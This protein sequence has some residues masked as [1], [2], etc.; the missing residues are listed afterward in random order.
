MTVTP[1]V[2]DAMGQSECRVTRSSAHAISSVTQSPHSTSL[3]LFIL[4]IGNVNYDRRGSYRKN[5]IDQSSSLQGADGG[6]VL[7]Q[8]VRRSCV[9]MCGVPGRALYRRMSLE[10]RLH[11]A[12]WT[13]LGEKPCQGQAHLAFSASSV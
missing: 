6:C 7:Q 2:S 11:A 12:Y 13:A 10:L 3:G 9:A 8:G 4:C 1:K 5:S